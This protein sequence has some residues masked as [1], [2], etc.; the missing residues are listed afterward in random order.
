MIPDKSNNIHIF[1]A[2]HKESQKDLAD[3]TGLSRHCIHK[4]ESGKSITNVRT[5]L[6]I[7]ARYN[8]TVEN[9]NFNH[10]INNNEE[11]LIAMNR[12]SDL[13][14]KKNSRTIS[15]KEQEELVNLNYDLEVYVEQDFT[16]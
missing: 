5:A 12:A 3:S 9:L 1:R 2:K 13:R 10:M 15:A 8:T 14:K 7:A 11:F 16:D 6:K 4:I